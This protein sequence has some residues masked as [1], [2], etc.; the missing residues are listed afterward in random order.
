MELAP[1]IQGAPR[2]VKKFIHRYSGCLE[3]LYLSRPA[4]RCRH[5]SFL[6]ISD[7]RLRW[8][9][10]KQQIALAMMIPFLMIM[11]LVVVQCAL[12]RTFTEQDEL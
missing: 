9:R 11:H 12:Q 4:S 2:S 7:T 10:E 3:F 8:Q 5:R 1:G 6:A